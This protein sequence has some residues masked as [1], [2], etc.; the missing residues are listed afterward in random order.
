M[1]AEARA[2]FKFQMLT[3][4]QKY[5]TETSKSNKIRNQYFVYQN[6]HYIRKI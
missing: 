3:L 4:L 1:N 2:W 5:P 6:T